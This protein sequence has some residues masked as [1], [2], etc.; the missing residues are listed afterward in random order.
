[1][2]LYPSRSSVKA[3]DAAK[4]VTAELDYVVGIEQAKAKLEARGASPLLA[5]ALHVSR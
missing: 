4:Y 3:S 2:R 1:M 5:I